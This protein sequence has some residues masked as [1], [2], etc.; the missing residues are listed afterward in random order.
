MPNFWP[1]ILRV[2]TP[3][4]VASNPCRQR[5]VEYRLVQLPKWHRQW[6]GQNTFVASWSQ[7][8]QHFGQIPAV[9]PQPSQRPQLQLS[10]LSFRFGRT[11]TGH[12]SDDTVQSRWLCNRRTTLVSG[13]A[14]SSELTSA[15]DAVSATSN[16]PAATTQT[17]TIRIW[18]PAPAAPAAYALI[19]FAPLARLRQ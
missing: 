17:V 8:A 12:R 5:F 10:E 16:L 14:I 15:L 4:S 2:F 6:R 11:S 19:I 13:A 9:L 18:G 3:D 1:F 7:T